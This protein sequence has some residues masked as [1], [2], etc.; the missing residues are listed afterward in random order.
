[1]ACDK[2]SYCAF[3]AAD[4]CGTA[5]NGVCTPI[6]AMCT[7]ELAPVCGCDGQT[8]QN[9]CLATASGA[10]VA[11]QGACG[12]SVACTSNADCNGKELCELADGCGLPGTCVPVPGL[13]TKELAP[14]CGCDGVTYDNACLA[15]QARASVDTRPAASDA[16]KS[17]TTVCGGKT[18]Q[19]CADTEFCDYADGDM[20]GQ[21]DQLGVCTPR[22]AFCTKQLAPVCGCDGTTYQNACL[23]QTAGVD[24]LAPGA[25]GATKQACGPNFPACGKGQYCA[26]TSVND[27]CGYQ[28]AGTCETIPPPCKAL[29]NDPPTTCGCDGKLYCNDCTAA[30]NGVGVGPMTV[31]QGQTP[32][33]CTTSKECGPTQLCRFTADDLC[34]KVSTGV[35]AARPTKCAPICNLIGVCACNGK[36]YCSECDAEANGVSVAPDEVCGA[37]PQ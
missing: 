37:L 10:S 1:V 27:A 8:Y 6:P 24:V 14:V 17:K 13:C 5:G 18:G 28:T 20:C 7:K 9:A 22:P 26:F 32:K 29:C 16:C 21:A 15:R 11:S 36:R 25:C 31:C 34:G 3:D 4:S 33:T 2:G 12:S 23:A 35:C 19:V 30:A